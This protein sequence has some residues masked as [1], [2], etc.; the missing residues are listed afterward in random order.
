MARVLQSERRGEPVV[1]AP[2]EELLAGR[3]AEGRWLDGDGFRRSHK[4][5]PWGTV[6]ISA[7]FPKLSVSLNAL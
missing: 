7:V 6:S 5:L 1:W 4:E 2:V 3:L